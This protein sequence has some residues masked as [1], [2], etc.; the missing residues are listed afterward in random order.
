MNPSKCFNRKNGKNYS[1]NEAT[2]MLDKKLE[3][4][5]V[6]YQKQYDLIKGVI[7]SDSKKYSKIKKEDITDKEMFEILV[8]KTLEMIFH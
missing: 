6:K 5:G 8:S 4:L 1:F 3:E 2:M 7:E